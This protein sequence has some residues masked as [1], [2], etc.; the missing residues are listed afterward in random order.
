MIP[1]FP[2]LTSPTKSKPNSSKTNAY[3]FQFKMSFSFG[4]PLLTQKSPDTKTHYREKEKKNLPNNTV[5]AAANWADGR[6]ILVR[7]LK[8]I[9]QKVVLNIPR[10][11]FSF[12]Y[13]ILH[14]C[15]NQNQE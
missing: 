5:G 3:P 11:L 15:M 12:N 2:N 13:L 14:V 7:N 9:T 6:D 8:K 10:R 1:I 4:I